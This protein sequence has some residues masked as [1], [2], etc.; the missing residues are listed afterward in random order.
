M[1]EIS[2]MYACL[3]SNELG[4]LN[5]VLQLRYVL[6]PFA[7]ICL[8][9]VFPSNISL[10]FPSFFPLLCFLSF[11][12]LP[13][14]SPPF[15]LLNPNPNQ[16]YLEGKKSLLY[17]KRHFFIFFSLCELTEGLRSRSRPAISHRL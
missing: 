14:F 4:I 15:P 1:K 17:I 5:K 10:S 11:P 6:L 3:M 7:L 2:K 8:F 9:F 12:S 16:I 13:F